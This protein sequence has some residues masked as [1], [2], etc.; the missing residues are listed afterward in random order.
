MHPVLARL[1]SIVSESISR[2]FNQ[3]FTYEPGIVLR[4]DWTTRMNPPPFTIER[5]A[6][7]PFSENTYF[8]SAPMRTKEHIAL[9]QEF[10]QSFLEA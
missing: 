9:V 2:D 5:R 6:D 1:T 7:I 4:S 10:E 8:A 3:T